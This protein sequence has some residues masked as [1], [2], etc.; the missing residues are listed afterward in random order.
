GWLWADGRRAKPD[1][2]GPGGAASGRRG[3]RAAAMFLA[4][5][6]A[7][8]LVVA[9]RN[10]VVAG[11]PVLISSNGG[12]NFYIRNNA[13]YDRTIRIR[14]GG[15]FER[16]A[17]EPA[18]L[19]VVGAAAQSRWFAARALAYLRADP[20]GAA[21]LYA[22]KARDLVA[23]REIPRNDSLDEYRRV[24]WILRALVWRL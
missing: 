2:A 14:P 6:A 3:A 24:S 8:V 11:E 1:G 7:P 18:N 17:Q 20:A 4:A 16:L 12:I 15:E 19:G 10:V 22:R 23:G 13:D 5:A 9:A 21:R